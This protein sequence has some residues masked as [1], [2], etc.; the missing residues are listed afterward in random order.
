MIRLAEL[1]LTA[2]SNGR[3]YLSN[4]GFLAHGI[5]LF[6][7]ACASLACIL[8]L[9]DDSNTEGGST[10]GP[11]DFFS[12]WTLFNLGTNRPT[13]HQLPRGENDVRVPIIAGSV[14]MSH[15]RELDEDDDD[16]LSTSPPVS[17]RVKKHENSKSKSKHQHQNAH[18]DPTWGQR[19][20]FS[21]HENA[22]TIPAGEESDF[23]DD[24]D[25]MAYLMSV[26]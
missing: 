13:F 20:V 10:V 24:A 17:K 2:L 6:G 21:S 26:R 25:A 14:N 1:Y 9:G 18:I 11:I 22:T 5:N 23:E 8:A 12:R 15:K 7:G 16:D 3:I 19:Y 4:H